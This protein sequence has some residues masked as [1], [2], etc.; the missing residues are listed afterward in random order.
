MTLGDVL[1]KTV[2][3]LTESPTTFSLGLVSRSLPMTVMITL[4][5]TPGETIPNECWVLFPSSFDRSFWEVC[6]RR[7]D[8]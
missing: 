5:L 3:E 4:L 2:L 6:L 8:T 7:F 1:C